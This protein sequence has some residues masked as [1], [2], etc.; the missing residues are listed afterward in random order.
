MRVYIQ[1][2][3]R[4]RF[5][6]GGQSRPNPQAIR[7]VLSSHANL[8]GGR[9]GRLPSPGVLVPRRVF[10]MSIWLSVGLGPAIFALYERGTDEEAWGR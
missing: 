5:C 6:T 9:G 10:S 2:P 4:F 8:A 7:L 1:T 3:H